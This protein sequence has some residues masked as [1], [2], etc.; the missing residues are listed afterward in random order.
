VDVPVQAL[1]IALAAGVGDGAEEDGAGAG[2]GAGAG[3][4]LAL[5]LMLALMLVLKM[6]LVRMLVLVLSVAPAPTHTLW[7][8]RLHC[9]AGLWCWH[10]VVPAMSKIYLQ[11]FGWSMCLSLWFSFAFMHGH[12]K[13]SFIR[14]M[15]S[16]TEQKTLAARGLEKLLL[17]WYCDWCDITFALWNSH[18]NNTVIDVTSLLRCGTVA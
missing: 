8:W 2:A 5:T 17:K 15:N 11:F 3:L 16:H 18:K 12:Q 6:A 1:K 10:V 7:R 13:E 9:G 4:M 14:D